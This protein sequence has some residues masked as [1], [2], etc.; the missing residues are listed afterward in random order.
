MKKTGTTPAAKPAA[1]SKRLTHQQFVEQAIKSLRKPPYKGIHVVYS[2][3]NSAFRAYFSEEPRP[4]IDKMVEDGFLISR[5]VRGGA[6]IMLATDAEEEKKETKPSE[7]NASATL[8]KIL[9]HKD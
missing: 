4:I 7:G 6:L 3:F 2:N 9:T 5:L 8:A 1:P